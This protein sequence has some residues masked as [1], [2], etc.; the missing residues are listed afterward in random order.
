MAAATPA[1]VIVPGAVVQLSGVEWAAREIM[2][3]VAG[4]IS[5]KIGPRCTVEEAVGVHEAA[6]VVIQF[7]LRCRLRGASIIPWE[8]HS[9]GR[10]SSRKA[11]PE[12]LKTPLYTDDQ[13]A[14]DY[15][16]L[17]GLNRAELEAA[18]EKLLCAYWPLVRRLARARS[19]ARR[20]PGAVAGGCCCARCGRICAARAPSR[21]RIAAISRPGARNFAAPW[22]GWPESISS[23]RRARHVGRIRKRS[24][25]WG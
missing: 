17:G 1:P 16:L 3:A 4:P 20:S 8:G 13:M 14:H 25:F 9:L 24:V 19:S 15:S 18:T 5:E 10:A 7:L 21:K 2:V 23:R 12:D 6:H 11:T 22:A